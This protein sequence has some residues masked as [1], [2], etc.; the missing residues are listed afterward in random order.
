MPIAMPTSSKVVLPRSDVQHQHRLNSSVQH[1]L[2]HNHDLRNDNNYSL[3]LEFEKFQNNR[4]NQKS[5]NCNNG[6]GNG[7][8]NDSND[9]N[10]GKPFDINWHKNI[11]PMEIDLN[12]VSEP[13][14]PLQV[15]A[16]DLDK[17]MVRTISLQVCD[18]PKP[19]QFQ[20]GYFM[21][22]DEDTKEYHHVY[23][24]P[25]LE[26]LIQ[27]LTHA[28]DNKL[29]K[30]PMMLCT[31]GTQKY[32]QTILR[33]C[34]ACH[35]F[36]I[37]LPRRDWHRRCFEDDYKSRRFKTIAR[38]ADEL[39]VAAE[40]VLMIDDDPGVYCK[41]DRTFGSLVHIKPFD[42]P[43]EQRNDRE[44]YKLMNFLEALFKYGRYWYI[45]VLGSCISYTGLVRSSTMNSRLITHN[46]LFRAQIVQILIL[47]FNI[48]FV[49]NRE[50]V[51]A[52]YLFDRY[53][54]HQ[55]IDWAALNSQALPLSNYV[56][57]MFTCL[58]L[59]RQYLYTDRK[60]PKQFRRYPFS[61]QIWLDHIDIYERIIRTYKALPHLMDV[62]FYESEMQQHMGNNNQKKNVRTRNKNSKNKNECEQHLF[63]RP[64]QKSKHKNQIL[65]ATII[66]IYNSRKQEQQ[67]QQSTQENRNSNSNSNSNSS[68]NQSQSDNHSNTNNSNSNN[69]KVDQKL[70]KLANSLTVEP[71]T[72]TTSVT[73]KS[74]AFEAD[75]NHM[76]AQPQPIKNTMHD[77]YYAMFGA[78]YVAAQHGFYTADGE[79]PLDEETIANHLRCNSHRLKKHKR[80]LREIYFNQ[81]YQLC[82]NVCDVIEYPKILQGVYGRPAKGFD[83][84]LFVAYEQYVLQLF[85]IVESSVQRIRERQY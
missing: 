60:R 6:N 48:R 54:A 67:M 41:A 5:D 78:E 62:D 50:K 32:A 20:N 49:D 53:I 2:E 46:T 82:S 15:L 19:Q 63:D 55:P 72:S 39:H 29:I 45:H 11:E 27:F 30:L 43:V 44:L 8:V 64:R 81:L 7:N 58:F 18:Q 74:I 68:N 66:N 76:I 77:T 51:I 56:L 84:S 52:V 71:M 22:F 4:N 35:L 25:G 40:D 70:N 24:R 69:A 42:D 59:G 75:N 26:K 33:K 12:C 34:G 28:V 80:R 57:L 14:Y 65:S 21:F 31:H 36:P 47:Q 13:L 10:N 61:A 1:R 3:L 38:M 9:S 23:K 79:G 73:P 17:T 85:A 83:S 16:W 37:M